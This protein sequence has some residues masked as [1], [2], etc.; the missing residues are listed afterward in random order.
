M[1]ESKEFVCAEWVRRWLSEYRDQFERQ[2]STAARRVRQLL[3]QRFAGDVSVDSLAR[4]VGVSRR[5]L[6]RQF[7]AQT[8]ESLNERQTRNRLTA[9]IPRLWRGECP[10]EVAWEVGWKSRVSLYSALR[11]YTG[12]NVSTLRSLEEHEAERIV[13][14]LEHLRARGSPRN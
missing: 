2:H 9:A 4:A 6:E 5:K 13:Q 7:R 10:K 8:G 12:H 11:R 14:S 3:E 1:P